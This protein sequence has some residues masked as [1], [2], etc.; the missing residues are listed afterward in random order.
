[1]SKS[2]VC[3]WGKCAEVSPSAGCLNILQS[4]VS[5]SIYLNQK[6][7]PGTISCCVRHKY[8]DENAFSGRHTPVLLWRRNDTLSRRL[9]HRL[10]IA[11]DLRVF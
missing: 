6:V 4:I 3:C 11:A 5:L 1:M 2:A 8:L 10:L 9:N 7:Y